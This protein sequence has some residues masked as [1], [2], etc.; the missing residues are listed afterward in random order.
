MDI[1]RGCSRLNMT[2]PKVKCKALELLRLFD[3]K[4]K[5]A[6]L[7][8]AAELAKHMICLD[9]ACQL[10]QQ[11]YCRPELMKLSG[12]SEREYSPAFVMV[13]S[14][15]KIKLPLSIPS[16]AIKLGCARV[17]VTAQRNLAEFQN[18]FRDQLSGTQQQHLSFQQNTA[19][20]AVALYLTALKEKLKVD[21]LELLR[22]CNCSMASFDSVVLQF[23]ELLPC[24][25]P[26]EVIRKE[27]KERMIPSKPPDPIPDEEDPFAFPEDEGKSGL[28]TAK[29]HSQSSRLE[30]PLIEKTTTGLHS[31]DSSSLPQNHPRST[32]CPEIIT[33]GIISEGITDTTRCL[34]NGCSPLQKKRPHSELDQVRATPTIPAP[35][36]GAKLK[37]TKLSFS[38]K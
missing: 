23:A 9:L 33:N 6:P 11:E 29:H 15:L 25:K 21:K 28:G 37:Q 4:S 5:S 18:K 10:M 12:V 22:L 27:G 2:D 35:S 30:D 26:P 31:V 24:L 17:Q 8:G 7:S 38:V 19:Y 14:V 3:V 16:V 13:Q 1:D 34:L 32:S 20:P 36:P